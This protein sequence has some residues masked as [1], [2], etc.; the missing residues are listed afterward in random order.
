MSKQNNLTDFL[1][2]LAEAIRNK[3]GTSEKI[4]PQN[5]S[6]EIKG[7]NTTPNVTIVTI[8]SGDTYTI[9]VDSNLN[10]I[11]IPYATNEYSV[12]DILKI[13]LTIDGKTSTYSNGL[14]PCLYITKGEMYCNPT[15]YNIMYEHFKEVSKVEIVAWNINADSEWVDYLIITF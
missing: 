2:D 3:K 14:I 8:E 5:F 12:A 6:D 9:D 11:V 15:F 1:T 4:D 7:L 10:Y 13:D